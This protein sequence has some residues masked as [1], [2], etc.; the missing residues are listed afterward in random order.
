M[1]QVK[2]R[3]VRVPMTDWEIAVF[4]PTQQFKKVKDE[5]VWRYSRDAYKV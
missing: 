3:I 5:S 1:S 4:M 2:S